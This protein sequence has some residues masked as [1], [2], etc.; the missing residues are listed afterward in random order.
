MG[1]IRYTTKR[2][3]LSLVTLFIVSVVTFGA[4]HILPG[5]AAQLLLGNNA[6]EAKIQAVRTQL[7][8]NRPLYIQY[9]DWIVGLLTLNLGESFFFG[10]PVAQ[11]I[12]ERF[13]PSLYLA[14]ASMAIAITTA[15]PLGIISAVKRNTWIDISIS[16]FVFAGLSVPSFF[17]GLVFIL[18]FAVFF[19]LVPPSGYVSPFEDFVGFLKTIILPATAIAWGFLAQITRMLRSSMLETASENFITTARAKGVPN[20][21]IILKHNL[22]NA[23]L[24]TLTVL[25]F[26]IGYVFSGLVVIEEV[27]AF[28]GIGRL[29][30]NAILQ[31]DIPVIQATVMVITGVFV[32]SN[33]VVDLLYSYI[34]PRIR[35]GGVNE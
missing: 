25:A 32:A 3:L 35:Y 31:R 23:L 19:D 28:P 16:S 7:G 14:I 13:P 30:F 2:L 18:V 26:Q 11:L 1:I 21:S 17:R 33:L 4:T 9:L 8:L 29:T 12:K 15:I 24:P 20:P 10:E 5:S 22:R 34:D 6:S 27:F